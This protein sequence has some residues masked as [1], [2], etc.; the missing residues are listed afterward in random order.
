MAKKTFVLTNVLVFLFTFLLYFISLLSLHLVVRQDTYTQTDRLSDLAV[1]SLHTSADY[2]PFL[3]RYGGLKGVHY[4]IFTLGGTSYSATH[5]SVGISEEAYSYEQL[6]AWSQSDYIAYDNFAKKDYCYRVDYLAQTDAFLRVGREVPSSYRVS[7]SFLLYGSIT[8]L[9]A[10]L[11]YLFLSYRKLSANL[12]ALKSQVKK[13]QNITSVER[14]VEYDDDLQFMSLMIRDARKELDTQLKEAKTNEQK[15]EF[16]LDS[17][18]QALVVIDASDKIVMFNKKASEIFSLGKDSAQ[19]RDIH[20]LTKGAKIEKNLSMVVKTQIPLAY[21]ENID[22]RYYECDINPIDYA[23]AK[24]NENSGASLLMIDVTESFNS[25]K[26][27]RDFFANAS[28]EL[29]S[30]LTTILGYQEMIRDGIITSPEEINDAIDKTVREAN[31]MKKIILDMLELS[32]LENEDLRPIEQLNVSREIDGILASLDLELKA[33]A[34]TVSFVHQDFMVGI[35][36]DDFDKLLRN[37]LENAIRYNRQGGSITIVVDPSQKTIAI[38]DTGIG[39]SEENKTRIFERFFRVDKARSQKN[40][41][42]G[43]GLAIVKYICSYY[44]Y[45]IDVE[46]TLGVGS[47]FTVHMK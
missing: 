23:W 45:T 47:T 9:A 14:V 42:T 32:S 24:V 40:G 20:V 22:G 19:G 3:V 28:H 13:L 41:G 46:S 8:L 26:M 11:V 39:I 5:D 38:S 30:P 16:V 6:Q 10:D 25:S 17:F 34:I 27:K 1:S 29:K 33:K 35:N 37:L 21:I 44:D 7:F 43:L 2:D 12:L 18:S 4:T 36:P 15:I 31:R